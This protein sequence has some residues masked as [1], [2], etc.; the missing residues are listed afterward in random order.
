MMDTITELRAAL[1]EAGWKVTRSAH[2][3]TCPGCLY[4]ALNGAS[5]AKYDEITNTG[6]TGPGGHE[7]TVMRKDS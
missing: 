1:N 2:G 7:A 4:A 5:L 6:Y 3:K